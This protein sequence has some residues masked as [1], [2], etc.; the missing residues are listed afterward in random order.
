MASHGAAV[1]AWRWG[2][3]GRPEE[4]CR[5]TIVDAI[6]YVVDNGCKW[7]ALPADFPPHSTVYSSSSGGSGRST[8][9]T[10]TTGSV[11]D[12]SCATDATWSQALP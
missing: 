7:R 3:G 9:T 10:C 11:T 12:S 5:R 1:A 6:R 4:H 8:W 2:R